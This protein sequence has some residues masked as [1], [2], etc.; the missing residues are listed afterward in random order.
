[1]SANCLKA[2]DR[3]NRNAPHGT[4]ERVVDP[5]ACVRDAAELDERRE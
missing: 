5:P 4:R 1:M 2:W 3:Q